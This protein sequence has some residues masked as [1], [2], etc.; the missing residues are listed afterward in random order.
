MG[1]LL[2]CLIGNI[3]LG[4]TLFPL[5]SAL[6][7]Q[8]ILTDYTGSIT[9]FDPEFDGIGPKVYLLPHPPSKEALI[10]SAFL[11]KESVG[12][13]AQDA[14]LKMYF[15]S[16]LKGTTSSL[17]SWTSL[18]KLVGKLQSTEGWLLQEI[19]RV[20]PLQL[21][22]YLADLQNLLASE[23]A[24]LGLVELASPLFETAWDTKQS[25]KQYGAAANIRFNLASMYA[26]N[27]LWTIAEKHFL[28]NYQATRQHGNATEQ[29]FA[30]MHLAY[31]RAVQGKYEEA[32]QSLISEVLPAFKR[33]NNDAGR[34][35]GYITLAS[36][37]RLQNRFPEVQWFLLQAKEIVDQKRLTDQLPDILFHLADAKRLSGNQ[38]VAINEYLWAH[39]LAEKKHLVAMQFA[40]Q[41]ALGSI[42]HA[43]GN[44]EEAAR[45]LYRYDA[46][47]DQLLSEDYLVAP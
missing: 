16:G 45:A 19:E 44:Y 40:I 36:I 5:N 30:K 4:L 12:L 42:Y 27:G 17:G 46:L 14:L 1:T 31:S 43:S 11:K 34:I 8:T 2:R 24:R 22:G 3:L 23:Y 13:N 38:T 39:E 18:P 32:E 6:A 33:L 9:K 25:L 37:Y 10:D 47:L 29:N 26:Y 41:D 15:L 21:P 7:Q 35:Q 28:Q 20:I